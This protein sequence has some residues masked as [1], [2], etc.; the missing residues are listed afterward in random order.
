MRETSKKGD[1]WRYIEIVDNSLGIQAAE[2]SRGPMRIKQA[3]EEHRKMHKHIESNLL[4][5]LYDRIVYTFFRLSPSLHFQFH[6]NKKI[7]IAKY[8]H[9]NHFY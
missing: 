6:T 5:N 4:L 2:Q 3:D 7:R 8:L 1:A 9:R